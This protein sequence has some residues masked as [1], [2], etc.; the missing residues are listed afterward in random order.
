MASMYVSARVDYAL[1]ALVAMARSE[2]PMTAAALADDQELPVNYLEAILLDLRRAGL[3]LSRRGPDAGYRFTVPPDQITVADVMRVLEGPLA[4][5]RG[6]R[7]EATSY[8]ES[9]AAI[10]DVWVALRAG[11]RRVLEHVTIA[12]LAVG[13]LPDHV[14][15]LVRD[16]EAWKPH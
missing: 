13:H 7:P 11:L 9:T 14:A 1:R 8:S 6:L 10:R 5:V 15:E 2:E 3:V 4:E 16:P 12:Q